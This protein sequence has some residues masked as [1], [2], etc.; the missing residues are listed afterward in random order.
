MLL[1]PPW[2]ISIYNFLWSHIC[3]WSHRSS[4]MINPSDDYLSSLFPR[5]LP[6]LQNLVHCIQLMV[7]LLLY[8]RNS[9]RLTIH[10]FPARNCCRLFLHT[11]HYPY[12]LI[13]VYPPQT[14][15][16]NIAIGQV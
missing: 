15:P 6:L 14:Y 9:S 2:S 11:H 16:H 4:N 8:P 7:Q 12:L 1:Q 3:Q 5:H 13:P 10:L